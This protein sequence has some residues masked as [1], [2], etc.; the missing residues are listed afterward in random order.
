MAPVVV[1]HARS[2][3]RVN[4]SKIVSIGHLQHA[5]TPPHQIVDIVN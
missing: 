4:K 3:D 2:I 5:E 1:H